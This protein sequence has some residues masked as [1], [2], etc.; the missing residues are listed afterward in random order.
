MRLCGE[1]L[2]RYE[3]KKYLS[4]FKCSSQGRPCGFVLVVVGMGQGFPHAGWG[5][6]DVDIPPVSVPR[7]GGYRLSQWL[8]RGAGLEDIQNQASKTNSDSVLHGDI[9]AET[10]GWKRQEKS[11]RNILPDRR[12]VTK[13]PK[14]VKGLEWLG[15]REASVLAT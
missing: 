13:K 5:L 1:S 2:E 4:Q 9:L 7:D 3:S 11:Q 8:P 6:H 10:R 15:N 14:A 12:N